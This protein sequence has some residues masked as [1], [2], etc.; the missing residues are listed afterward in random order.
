MRQFVVDTQ[1][2]YEVENNESDLFLL[3]LAFLA[4][5]TINSPHV[6]AMDI[7]GVIQGQYDNLFRRSTLR[8]AEKLFKH[9]KNNKRIHFYSN[10][11]SLVVQTRLRALG[12]HQDDWAFVGV[13]ASSLDKILIA[14]ESDY[15]ENIKDYLRTDLSVRVLRVKEAIAHL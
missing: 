12:F 11:L 1:V 9:I 7:E 13:A 4:D 6:L 10:R 5:F 14:E 3:S 8:S 15:S 2:F